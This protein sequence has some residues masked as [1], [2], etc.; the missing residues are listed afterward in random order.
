MDCTMD[1]SGVKKCVLTDYP[2]P[3]DWNDDQVFSVFVNCYEK[4]INEHKLIDNSYY[5]DD[6]GNGIIRIEYL[7]HYVILCY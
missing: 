7:D 1:Y 6:E 5:R 2:F 4:L 3:L